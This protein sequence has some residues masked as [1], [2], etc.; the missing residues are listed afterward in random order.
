MGA[1]ILVSNFGGSKEKAFITNSSFTTQNQTNT[2]TTWTLYFQTP[3][4]AGNSYDCEPNDSP[5]P[6]IS[7]D[8]PSTATY[9]RG[10]CTQSSSTRRHRTARRLAEDSL[11]KG[12]IQRRTAKCRPNSSRRERG[13]LRPL[14]GS[15]RGGSRGT[16]PQRS[17]L[18][19]RCR[20]RGEH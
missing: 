1:E 5:N 14:Y 15:R 13:H 12:T 2:L 11:Q 16:W 7:V 9:N 10:S 8:I 19:R 4:P 18:R 3:S 17:R 20:R 6:S